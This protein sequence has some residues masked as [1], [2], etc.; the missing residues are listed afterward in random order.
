MKKDKRLDELLDKM[1]H[2]INEDSKK[3]LAV[4]YSDDQN[5]EFKI[6]DL[7][8]VL[9]G[10]LVWC[11]TKGVTDI[12]EHNIG[13]VAIIM[14]SYHDIYGHGSKDK[15][16]IKYLDTGSTEAWKG[17]D[18]LEMLKPNMNLR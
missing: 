5:T 4:V 8:K 18:E 2:Q 6:G 16:S 15:Y 7:V 14:G 17:V 12:A 13:K 9:I 1:E 11:S 3:R 10:H